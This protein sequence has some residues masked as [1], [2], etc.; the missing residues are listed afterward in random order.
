MGYYDIFFNIA[1]AFTAICV[2]LSVI[3]TI[4]LIHYFIRKT[5]ND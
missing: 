3:L 5:R 1:I 4:V 2:V